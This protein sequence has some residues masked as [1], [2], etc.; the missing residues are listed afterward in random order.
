M[1][2]IRPW[3]KNW[4]N[5]W[6]ICRRKCYIYRWFHRCSTNDVTSNCYAARSRPSHWL[7]VCRQHVGI[8]AQPKFIYIG[9]WGYR[10]TLAV[11]RNIFN[12]CL[13]NNNASIC[14]FF[15]S[16]PEYK[17][18][19]HC[20]SLGYEEILH[21]LAE[22]YKIRIKI[23]D[24]RARLFGYFKK[25]AVF[26]AKQEEAQIVV[27]TS[28][29]SPTILELK[30]YMLLSLTQYWKGIHIDFYLHARTCNYSY[31]K[32]K[33]SIMK[34]YASDSSKNKPEYAGFISVNIS[35]IYSY[36]S[37]ITLCLYILF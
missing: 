25:G 16:H 18:H 1:S 35:I 17:I 2:H 9:M 5:I 32:K 19:L 7:F 26:V 28:P 24:L 22:L 12:P 11:K 15:S 3:T 20:D 8:F 23:N 10:R 29:I 33:I 4:I 27:K 21:T 30:G 6:Y 34:F 36:D 37:Y 31:E 14:L 13:V